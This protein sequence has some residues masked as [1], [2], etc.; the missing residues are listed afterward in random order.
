MDGTLILTPIL[1]RVFVSDWE[2]A[3]EFYSKTLGRGA[4]ALPRSGPKRAHPR[5]RATQKAGGIATRAMTSC[6]G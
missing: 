1:I 4:R 5:G 2:R 6:D 3:V